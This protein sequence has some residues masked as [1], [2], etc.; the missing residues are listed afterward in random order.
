MTVRFPLVAAAVVAVVF[1]FR[2]PAPAAAQQLVTEPPATYFASASIVLQGGGQRLGD[3]ATFPLYDETA[4]FDVA[5]DLDSGAGFEIGGGA[6]LWHN[7]GAGIIIG[8]AGGSGEGRISA[9]LPHPVLFGAPRS[10]ELVTELDRSERVVHLQAIWTVPVRDRLDVTVSLGPSFYSV[11]QQVVTEVFF[12]E[13]PEP[14]RSVVLTGTRQP[15]RSEG[16]VGFNLG[17]DGVY[18]LTPRIGGGLTLRYSGASVDLP[19]AAG[20][21]VSVDAGGFQAAV[22]VRVRF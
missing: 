19:G 22:G 9:S 18:M 3:A 16:A 14:F 15:E 21:D 8:R 4:R 5:Y 10:A 1:L 12:A 7:V 2:T 17:V 20:N 11:R 13:G 6:H